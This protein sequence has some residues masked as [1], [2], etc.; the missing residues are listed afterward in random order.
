MQSNFCGVV[1]LCNDNTDICKHTM[2]GKTHNERQ[3][4]PKQKPKQNRKKKKDNSAINKTFT[5]HEVIPERQ[6]LKEN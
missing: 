5:W 6:Q 1:F 3:N 4:K 2:K